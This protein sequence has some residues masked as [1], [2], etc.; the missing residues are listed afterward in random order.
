MTLSFGGALPKASKPLAL[1]TP[2]PGTACCTPVDNRHKQAKP[3][4]ALHRGCFA[5]ELHHAAHSWNCRHY[6]GLF[7]SSFS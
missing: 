5:F 7:P 6:L 3:P 2:A 4:D 1:F